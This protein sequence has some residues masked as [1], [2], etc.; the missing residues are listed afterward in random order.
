MHGP[1]RRCS[2]VSSLP[3]CWHSLLNLRQLNLCAGTP[4]PR[5]R[6]HAHTGGFVSNGAKLGA[7]IMVDCIRPIVAGSPQ[8]KQATKALPQVDPQSWRRAVSGIS[9]F[10]KDRRAKTQILILGT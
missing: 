7:G 9:D 2:L 8:R 10:G 3:P 5:S 6:R 4:S 1:P